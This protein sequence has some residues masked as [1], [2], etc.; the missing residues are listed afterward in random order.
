MFMSCCLHR[1][2]VFAYSYDEETN[3][4]NTNNLHRSYH[5]HLRYVD[6]SRRQLQTTNN[7]GTSVTLDIDAALS[8]HDKDSNENKVGSMYTKLVFDNVSSQY[9]DSE[10][11]TDYIQYGVTRVINDNLD[12]ADIEL[13]DVIFQPSNTPELWLSYPVMISLRYPS[14]RNDVFAHVD[15]ILS[16]NIGDISMYQDDYIETTSLSNADEMELELMFKDVFI[17]KG[18]VETAEEG[19]PTPTQAPTTKKT[20]FTKP[21]NAWINKAA[22]TTADS[23]STMPYW[24]WIILGCGLGFMAMCCCGFA[25]LYVMRRRSESD[26]ARKEESAAVH[27]AMKTK[28]VSQTD[29]HEREEIVK[30]ITVG[31]KIEQMPV[32]QVPEPR[33]TAD[34][35]QGEVKAAPQ[36]KIRDEEERKEQHRDETKD[37]QKPQQQ[38]KKHVSEP[39][40]QVS[41]PQMPEQ[42]PSVNETDTT[43]LDPEV[44]LPEPDERM[45][46]VL[47]GL[48]PN[49]EPRK[50]SKK[51]KKKA[52]KKK[53]E[54]GTEQIDEDKM[55]FEQWLEHAT[56]KKST[57]KEKKKKSGSSVDDQDIGP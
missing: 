56:T 44:I 46:E 12:A 7:N 42:Q 15:G 47:P 26:A 18:R 1:F 27:Q 45:P 17:Q 13:I 4:I 9:A 54:E 36:K 30:P 3:S 31:E 49:P 35:D 20:T 51:K 23:L 55:S 29:S 43:D 40:P 50:K 39:D 53:D 5:R 37:E 33:Y 52:K 41:E 28:S 38:A 14:G 10:L 57:K 34:E 22:D 19:D 48:Y 25:F 24:G 8:T 6:S 32:E 21:V 16:S 11:L 2:A